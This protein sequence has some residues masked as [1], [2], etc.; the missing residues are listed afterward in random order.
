MRLPWKKREEELDDEMEKFVKE[1]E[2][3]KRELEEARRRRFIESRRLTMRRQS[4]RN[5]E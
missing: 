4:A 5:D 1:G 3:L 2:E